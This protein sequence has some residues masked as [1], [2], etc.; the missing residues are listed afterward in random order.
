LVDE[1]EGPG[2]NHRPVTSHWHNVIHNIVHFALIEIR[3]HNI[4]DERHRL[5][6][7][8]CI[9]PLNVFTEGLVIGVGFEI[10]LVLSCLC[11]VA[12]WI[13]MK[14]V[15]NGEYYE[16]LYISCIHIFPLTKFQSNM[17]RL[18]CIMLMYSLLA[19]EGTECGCTKIRSIA[20]Y[21]FQ[22]HQ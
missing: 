12:V 10:V 11:L 4:S 13:L 21:D 18:V 2:A 9:Y 17:T 19:R 15:N 3:T 1:T 14:L 16:C 7:Y 20:I 5:H 8:I 6:I 22:N